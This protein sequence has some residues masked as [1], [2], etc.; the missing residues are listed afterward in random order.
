[1]E[2]SKHN[3][4]SAAQSAEK[5]YRNANLPAPLIT[6]CV[7]FGISAAVAKEPNIVVEEFSVPSD[8]PGIARRYWPNRSLKYTVVA[9]RGEAGEPREAVIRTPL[10]ELT[11]QL[12]A[13]QFAQVHRSVVVNLNA[14]ARVVRGSNE[15]ADI[16]LKGRGEVL[17][18]SRSY[19]HLFRQM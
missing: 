8:D 3:R 15:T 5:S 13:A 19:L 2:P 4:S 18:V 14:V 7:L 9:W 12:D 16:Y 10:K 6:C 11:A 17:P 1:M